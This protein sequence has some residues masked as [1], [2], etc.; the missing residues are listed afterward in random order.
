MKHSNGL[1][2]D[3]ETEL[4]A[5]WKRRVNQ[6]RPTTLPSSK[7]QHRRKEKETKQTHTGFRVAWKPLFSKK[8]E[9]KKK[10]GKEEKKSKSPAVNDTATAYITHAGIA[11]RE[12]LIW[13]TLKS[14]AP[15][16]KNIV[17]SVHHC[18]V[19]GRSKRFATTRTV[20]EPVTMASCRAP[21]Y[22]PPDL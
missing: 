15:E 4:G 19:L 12:M 6:T 20:V 22:W 10:E 11:G 16:H 9:N 17:T 21:Y 5:H 2:N 13:T 8:K 14:F 18:L 3:V 7:Q 1:M